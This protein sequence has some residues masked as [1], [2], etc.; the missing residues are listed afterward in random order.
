[1]EERTALLQ[2]AVG[3]SS[4][5]ILITSPDAKIIFINKAWELMTGYSFDDTIGKNPSELW[6]GHMTNNFY[7]KLWYI[8]KTEKKPFSGELENVKKNGVKYW[9]ESHITPILDEYGE[10]KF[11]MAIAAEV[12]EKKQKE[13]FRDEFVSIIGHQLRNPLITISWLIEWLSKST[14]LTEEDKEKIKN[15]YQQ[16][17]GLSSFVEDLLMLSR[18]GKNNLT[19]EKFDFKSEIQMILGEVQNRNPK[20]KLNF[21]TEGEGL[22]I[23]TNKSMAT[24]VFSNLIYNAAEY[25]DK[26]K[27][28][29]EVK[30]AKTKDGLL[31]SSYNNGPE[32]TEGDKPK[33]FSKLF[34]SDL[35]KEY[36]KSG[37]G[38]G[39]FIVKTICDSFGWNVWFE[40]GA[41]LG[42]TF[43][44]KIPINKV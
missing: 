14:N 25:A 13:Q 17:K 36:K 4:Q 42:T 21:Y 30:I 38:L 31:F 33:I 28:E 29:V 40:S 19:K 32:I 41:G 1:M 35:A 44:V 6:G 5:S 20:V 22:F 23:S 39:L 10:I 11:F 43:Y 18:A 24:Q 2:S 37:T 3:S 16:N 34:R 26:D 27:G 9:Q 12:T 7:E 15:I 8:I